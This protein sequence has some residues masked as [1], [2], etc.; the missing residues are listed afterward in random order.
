MIKNKFTRNFLPLL[1]R[2]LVLSDYKYCSLSDKNC[3]PMFFDH[4]HNIPNPSLVHLPICSLYRSV[5]KKLNEIDRYFS[6][7]ESQKPSGRSF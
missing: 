4:R 3:H 2:R 7:Y 6:F 1:G 5:I